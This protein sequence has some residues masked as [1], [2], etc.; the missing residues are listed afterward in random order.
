MYTRSQSVG[1][2]NCIDMQCKG[3]LTTTNNNKIKK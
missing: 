3:R 1:N 2:V